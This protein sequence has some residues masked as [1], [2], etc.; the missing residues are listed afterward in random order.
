LPHCAG[1]FQLERGPRTCRVACSSHSQLLHSS[2]SYL[3]PLRP[4]VSTP[5]GS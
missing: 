1:G 5:H 3:M 2:T 4:V